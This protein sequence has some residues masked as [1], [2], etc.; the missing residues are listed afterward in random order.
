MTGI[1]VDDE[2]ELP[3][4]TAFVTLLLYSLPGTV[5]FYL[6]ENDWGIT[7]SFY[8]VFVSTSTIGFGDLVPQVWKMNL[9]MN[10]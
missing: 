10:E 7:G 5:F 3:L 8:F 1:I 2:F 9:K 6:W 4:K